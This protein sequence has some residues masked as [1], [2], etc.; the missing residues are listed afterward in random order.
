MPA[1]LMVHDIDPAEKIWKELGSAEDDIEIF[2]NQVLVAI[3]KRPEK[4]KGGVY[5]TDTTRDED[6]FQGRV[7][8]IVMM[9]NNAFKDEDGKWFRETEFSEGDWVFYRNSDGS[10]IKINGVDC[11]IMEDIYIKGRVVRPDLV[12]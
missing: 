9:G 8:M 7:G 5:Y 10:S 6:R 1:A 4:T 11:R 3:Y 12:F 2:N